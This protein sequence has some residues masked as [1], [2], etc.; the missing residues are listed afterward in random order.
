MLSPSR[1]SCPARREIRG[2]PGADGL[3]H[4]VD[5]YVRPESWPARHQWVAAS[6]PWSEYPSTM[7]AEN[8]DGSSNKTIVESNMAV[9]HFLFKN[10]RQFDTA[11]ICRSLGTM[12]SLPAPALQQNQYHT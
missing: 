6:R 10:G 12:A 4:P 11:M 5:M 3:F 2:V 9:Y 1:P 8:P 7:A